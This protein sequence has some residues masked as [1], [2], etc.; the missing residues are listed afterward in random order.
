MSYVEQH[1]DPGPLPERPGKVPDIKDE[2][3]KDWNKSARE[4]IDAVTKM[5]KHKIALAID[6]LLKKSEKQDGLEAADNICMIIG[7][8]VLEDTFQ[9]KDH[10][11][12]F[13]G[14]FGG[15]F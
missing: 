2:K 12:P 15:L 6:G 5:R 8:M 1:P 14:L 4:Y 9:Q 10:L 11:D 7:I 3:R 13:R